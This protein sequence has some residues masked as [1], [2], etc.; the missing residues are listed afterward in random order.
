MKSSFDTDTIL[1][2]ILRDSPVMGIISG[3]IYYLE[4]RPDD[5]CKEDI[6]INTITLTQ[7]FLP[8]IGFSNINI[9]VLD[10]DIV[11]DGKL[12]RCTDRLRLKYLAGIVVNSLRE[13][14]IKGLKIIVRW[15]N[16]FQLPYINQSFMN[17]RIKWNIQID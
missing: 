9:Y 7:D 16:I 5:S 1:F 15:Q 2:R 12:Q 17:I 8:Q 10:N 14:N 13:A 11:V 3:D 6:I 4:D